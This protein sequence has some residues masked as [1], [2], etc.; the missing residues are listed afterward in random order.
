MNKKNDELTD[1]L[2]LVSNLSVG[3]KKT[4]LEEEIDKLKNYILGLE[5][6]IDENPFDKFYKKV[7]ENWTI[8]NE[9]EGIVDAGKSTKR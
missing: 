2:T 6:S 9:K 4:K 3:K 7:H 8:I 5:T 1:K